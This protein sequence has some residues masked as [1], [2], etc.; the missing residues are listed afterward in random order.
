MKNIIVLIGIIITFAMFGFCNEEFDFDGKSYKKQEINLK[1]SSLK[2]Q[3][4]RLPQ[5]VL[6]VLDGSGN[7][8]IMEPTSTFVDENGNKTNYYTLPPNYIAEWYIGCSNN[9]TWSAKLTYSYCHDKCGGHYHYTPPAPFLKYG[10][11]YEQSNWPQTYHETPSPIYFPT[12]TGNSKKYYYYFWYPEY[13]MQVTHWIEAFG[14][15][16]GMIT[17]V[18]SVK[19][20]EKLIE[21]KP[22]LYYVLAGTTTSHPYN[23]Y[24]TELLIKT[25][26]QIASEYHSAFPNASLIEINDMSLPWGGLFDIKD[27]WEKPHNLHRCGN[28]ADIRKVTIP[29]ETREKFLEIACK[30]VIENVGKDEGTVLLELNPPHYHISIRQSE[31]TDFQLSYCRPSYSYE[32]LDNYVHCCIFGENNNISVNPECIK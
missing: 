22:S 14:A 23:H 27:N 17:N 12:M 1:E 29:P 9:G 20:P 10:G 6:K 24:G 11:I 30:K 8:Y 7:S 21:M 31:I 25:L 28:Q 4:N 26:T 5:N 18:L 16:S 32:E 15:C 19:V 3:Q 13:S 2:P